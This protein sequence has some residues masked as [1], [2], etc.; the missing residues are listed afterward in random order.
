MCTVKGPL[1]KLI[2]TVAH[3]DV[4][5]E[6]V[7]AGNGPPHQTRTVASAISSMDPPVPVLLLRHLRNHNLLVFSEEYGNKIPV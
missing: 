3:M 6:G 7:V 1:I 4:L 5:S 2:L